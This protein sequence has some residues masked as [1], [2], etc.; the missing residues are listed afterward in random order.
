MLS[1]LFWQLLR[2]LMPIRAAVPLD[3]SQCGEGGTYCLDKSW[4]STPPCLGLRPVEVTQASLMTI[5]AHP[6]WLLSTDGVIYPTCF[7]WFCSHF[8]KRKPK[9]PLIN[10][11]ELRIWQIFQ[12]KT[13]FLV[14]RVILIEIHST[15]SSIFQPSS[16]QPKKYTPSPRTVALFSILNLNKK[17]TFML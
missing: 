13:T 9:V 15:S 12:E 3:P 5:R 6:L 2:H 10:Q 1:V 14:V 17:N 16:S 11:F 8:R 7:L 4:F